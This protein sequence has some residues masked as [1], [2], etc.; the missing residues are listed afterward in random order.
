MKFPLNGSVRVLIVDDERAF[1]R[2]F[3]ELVRTCGHE[4]VDVVFSG[5][6]AIRSYHR[7]RPD[8]VLMDFKMEHLNG[9]TA[10][11]NIL[12]A[13]PG[14]RIIFLTG[15]TDAEDLAPEFSGA[16]AWL[17]KPIRVQEL[18]DVLTRLEENGVGSESTAKTA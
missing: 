3:A 2:T 5:L 17:K 12:S 4:V 1:A 8:V 16:V 7:H 6:E 18:T 9:L 14:A 10:C 11:R 15:L 13:D